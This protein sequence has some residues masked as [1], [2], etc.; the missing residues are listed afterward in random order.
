LGIGAPHVRGVEQLLVIAG[1]NATGV[2]EVAGA[3]IAALGVQL[4]Q[5]EAQILELKRWQSRCPL[6][7][8]V[9]NI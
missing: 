7:P 6:I 5:L 3:C 2:P 9:T 1:S 8:S 4:H